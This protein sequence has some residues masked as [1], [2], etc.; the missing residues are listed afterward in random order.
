VRWSACNVMDAETGE[1]RVWQFTVSGSQVALQ[2]QH[3]AGKPSKS[4]RAPTW[5]QLIQPRLNLAWL[6]AGLVYL[7]V[8]HL[9]RCEAGELPAMVELQIEKVSP[10]PV[11]QIVWSYELLPD[12]ESETQTV[13]VLMASRAEVERHLGVLERAG[14]VPDRLELSLLHRVACERA[15]L[16]TISLYLEPHEGDMLCLAA[17][18]QDGVLQSL[19][20]LRVTDDAVGPDRLVEQLTRLVWAGEFEGWLKGLHPWKLV[21]DS[22]HVGRWESRLRDWLGDQVDSQPAVPAEQAALLAA[23]HAARHESSANL[24][25]QDYLQRYRQQLVD[26][27]WMR[28]LAT[29]LAL[30]LLGVAVYAAAVQYHSF[31][32]DRLKR[33]VAALS[34]AYTNAL[35]LKERVRVFEEQAAL[36]YAALDCLLSV[37]ERL[38]EVMQLESFNFQGGSRLFLAGLVSRDEQSRVTAFNADLRRAQVNQQPLFDAS[39]VEP[40]RFSPTAADKYRWDFT[41]KLNVPGLE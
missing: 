13:V 22:A 4:A 29:L 1:G 5:R 20:L 11:A 23:Q 32:S 17:W 7:R 39:G 14:F 31:R 25:P 3:A 41:A 34:P 35:A 30:Y 40:P 9:P 24:V 37:S 26:R 6:P 19:D 21:M 12:S 8:L 16:N 10:L 38:P 33:E 18:R 27:L 28:G 36:K 2:G 15:E